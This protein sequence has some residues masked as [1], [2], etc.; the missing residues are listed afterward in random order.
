MFTNFTNPINIH[1]NYLFRSKT[2]FPIQQIPIGWN[3]CIIKLVTFKLTN[4]QQEFY[5]INTS[6][7]TEKHS[8]CECCDL[9]RPTEGHEDNTNWGQPRPK[10]EKAAWTKRF[11][12]LGEAPSILSRALA[13]FFKTFMGRDALLDYSLKK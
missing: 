12:C 8:I 6:F 4:R 9:S 10:V 7:L 13:T 11:C 5:R 2:K 3:S 1:H